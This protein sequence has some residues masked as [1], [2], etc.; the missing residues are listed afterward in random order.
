MAA[1]ILSSMCAL[2][3]KNDSVHEPTAATTSPATGNSSAA[4]GKA[5]DQMERDLKKGSPL[6]TPAGD[7]KEDQGR[8]A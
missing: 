8:T 4:P 7:E 1:A 6:D 3:I 2:V 5:A